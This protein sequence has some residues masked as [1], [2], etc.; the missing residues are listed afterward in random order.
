MQDRQSR[1]SQVQKRQANRDAP[2]RPAPGKVSRTGRMGT[3]P[4]VQRQANDA[5]SHAAQVHEAAAAGVQGGGSRMPHAE[6]IQRAFGMAH[7]VSSI[8]AHVGGAA[9]EA[10]DAIGASAYATGNDV[11]F[12]SAP[13]LHTA[14]HEAAHVVQQSQGVQLKGGVGEVGDA[15]ERHADAVAD[16]VVAGESAA[17]LLAAGPGG[18][19]AGVQRKSAD[20]GVLA[21]QGDWLGAGIGA[22]GGAA[23][24]A[25]IGA[26][27]G[28]PVGAL[29]GAGVG[30]VAGA[31]GGHLA[32]EAVSSSSVL[33]AEATTEVETAIREGRKQDAVNALVADLAAQGRIDTGLLAGGV[34]TYDASVA[35]EGVANPPGYDASGKALP[36]DVRVGDDAFANGV[37]LLHTSVMHEY[38]HVLQFQDAA[39]SPSVVPGQGGGALIDQQEVEAYAWEIEHAEDTGLSEKPAMMKDAW[40]RLHNNYWVNLSAADKAPLLARV[41]NCHQIA[42]RV[43][44]ETLTFTP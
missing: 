33:S 25:G 10:S 11:A 42:E 12:K 19:A 27:V 38:W 37:V 36:T 35:G 28:G 40:R 32:E 14:A 17:D 6:T 26:L 15:Y 5:G 1:S 34:I 2:A 41:T 7:D 18:G 3:S 13:D 8:Q 16:R 29:V 21:V 4:G 9:A 30:A 31:V 39:T 23:A 20:Q 44:G 43:S 24:G 22:A